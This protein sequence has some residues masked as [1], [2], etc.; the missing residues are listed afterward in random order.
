MNTNDYFHGCFS[1]FEIKTRYRELCKIHHPD[2]GGS[3]EA[4]QAVN[5]AYEERLRGEFRKE[6]DNDTAE[7]F[8]DLEREVA[9]KVAE[10]ISLQGI[11]VELVGRWVWV[12]GKTYPVRD[13]LKRAG[14]YWASKKL[15]WY[16]HKAEDSCTS[17]GKKSLEEIKA[18]YGSRELRDG[19]SRLTA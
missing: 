16:W 7:D 13:L 2:L 15:A 17:H 1:E 3:T 4:M 18:K 8:V 19:R 6:Y 14:F 11:I 5:A 12:T 10:I 9:A